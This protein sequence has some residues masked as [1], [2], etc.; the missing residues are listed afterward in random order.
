MYSVI[1][2]IFVALLVYDMPYLQS[3]QHGVS[4]TTTNIKYKK[5]MKQQLI[6]PLIATLALTAA[7]ALPAHSVEKRGG[8]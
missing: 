7:T 3:L 5:Y 4:P 1:F 2:C 8:R 6:K